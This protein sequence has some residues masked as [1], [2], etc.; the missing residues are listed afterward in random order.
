MPSLSSEVETLRAM[1]C[2]DT[3]SGL[4]LTVFDRFD[5]LVLPELTFD[6]LEVDVADTR[7][8]CGQSFWFNR[9]RIRR[10]QTNMRKIRSP[11]RVLP[12]SVTNQRNFGPPTAKETSS[13]AQ[14]IPITMNSFKYKLNLHY[15]KIGHD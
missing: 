10:F 6:P 8:H 2:I 11:C 14:L 1:G 15:N 13:I 7:F 9:R 3:L 5:E 4:L 12:K